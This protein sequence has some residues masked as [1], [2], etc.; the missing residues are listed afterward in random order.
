MKPG[1]LDGTILRMA[2]KLSHKDVEF[3]VGDQVRVH[4]RIKEGD[5]SREAVFEG[6]VLG[7]K[8][9]APGK[10]FTVRR[11]GE[12]G[13]GIEKIFPVE[14][15]TIEKIAVVKKGTEG[16]RRAK[17]YYTRSKAPT[18]VDLIFRRATSRVNMKNVSAKKSK[19]GI[20]K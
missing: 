9:R 3:G 20:R 14:L 8:G 5:K 19:K 15:P 13:V 17:L 7:I 6:M 2:F 18:E 10:T 4:Q 11:V 12:A 16:V 1:S